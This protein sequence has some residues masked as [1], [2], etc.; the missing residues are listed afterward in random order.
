VICHVRDAATA[1]DCDQVA[2][3]FRRLEPGKRT[4]AVMVEAG[5]F[6]PKTLCTVVYDEAGRPIRSHE[7]GERGFGS[8]EK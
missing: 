7:T 8:S 4:L 3:A 5:M 2:T 6:A 1:P